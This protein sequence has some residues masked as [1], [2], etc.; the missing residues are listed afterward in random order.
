MVLVSSSASSDKNASDFIDYT[1]VDTCVVSAVQ[2]LPYRVFWHP[3]S[4]TYAPEKVAFE[5]YDSA[6]LELAASHSPAAVAAVPSFYESPV[7]DVVN[8]MRLQTFELPRRVVVSSATTVLR[9]KLL[10][11]HQAQTFE[12]PPWLQRTAEDRL[13]KYYCCLSYVNVIGT[14]CEPVAHKQLEVVAPLKEQ[15]LRMANSL[16]E[17]M[18]SCYEGIMEMRRRAQ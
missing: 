16:A 3:G 14:S 10:G 5:F 11:R 9:V 18:T 8:A 4:P 2:I 1:L 13:P 15:S 6:A 17:Y 7:Y 12:L